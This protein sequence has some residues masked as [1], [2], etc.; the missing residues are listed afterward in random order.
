MIFE[1]NY[2]FYSVTKGFSHFFCKKPQ[3]CLFFS[4][5]LGFLVEFKEAN[6]NIM[7]SHAAPA[8]TF[9]NE[10][11]AL[12]TSLLM[13]CLDWKVIL[14][15][16]FDGRLGCFFSE[17]AVKGKIF[18]GYYVGKPSIPRLCP[19]CIS[20]YLYMYII[21]TVHTLMAGIF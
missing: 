15:R 1:Y 20:V 7:A 4:R 8:M 6:Q 18:G 10:R 11:D 5:I 9:C 14:H 3:V 12:R 16:C 17:R 21:F 2:S 19:E 13:C